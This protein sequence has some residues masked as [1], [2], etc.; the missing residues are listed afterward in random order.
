MV[1]CYML[2][3]FTFLVFQAREKSWT[4]D[5]LCYCLFLNV[6][7]NMMERVNEQKMC[8]HRKHLSVFIFGWKIPFIDPKRKKI[9]ESQ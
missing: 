9:R 5:K 8:M 1:S 7:Y 2:R 4:E 3:I 6:F